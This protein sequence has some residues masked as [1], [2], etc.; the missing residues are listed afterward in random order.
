MCNLSALK[1]QY[2]FKDFPW[3]DLIDFKVKAPYIPSNIRE[4][5]N[6][7]RNLSNP[8]EAFVSVSN[9]YF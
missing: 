8:F 3:D 9:N 2:L 5:S 1:S 6:N 7:L 4:W